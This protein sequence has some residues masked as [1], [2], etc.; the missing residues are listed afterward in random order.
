MFC[1]EALKKD[2]KTLKHI[3]LLLL[4]SGLVAA[5][6]RGACLSSDR[7]HI[8]VVLDQTCIL[9]IVS[10]LPLGTTVTRVLRGQP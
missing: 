10:L 4:H 2:I 1:S 7:V 5:H 9:L 8:K 3:L 6:P